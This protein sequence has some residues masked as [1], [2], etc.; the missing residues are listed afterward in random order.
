MTERRNKKVSEDV[1]NM[2]IDMLIVNIIFAFMGFLIG[3]LMWIL[4]KDY[5]CV[6]IFIVI[7]VVGT[8]LGNV[9]YLISQ[10]R[11]QNEEKE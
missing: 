8:I 4:T 9:R 3:I 5:E 11:K 1:K 10:K 7:F 6:K 2:L